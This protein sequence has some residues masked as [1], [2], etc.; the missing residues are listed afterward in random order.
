MNGLSLAISS[1]RHRKLRTA[2]TTLSV[3]VA[4]SVLT[5][6]LA[7]LQ[8]IYGTI[9]DTDDPRIMVQSRI[10]GGT[11]PLAYVE[12]I[13]GLAGVHQVE[14]TRHTRGDDGGRFRFLIWAASE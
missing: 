1:L 11:M 3:F 4:I 13:R 10:V 5:L 6:T 14:F 7:A 9:L 8:T 2:L 12:Q